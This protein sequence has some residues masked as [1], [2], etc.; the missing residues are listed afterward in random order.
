M[1]D[2]LE[3]FEAVFGAIAKITSGDESPALG[4]ARCPKCRASDFIEVPEL[5]SEAVGR[6]EESPES[7]DQIHVGGMSDAR[8]VRR[9][10]PPTRRSPYIVPLLFAVPLGAAAFYLQRRYGGTVG[11]LAIIG[12]VVVT[13]VVLMTTFRKRSDEYYAARQ[14]WRNLFMCRKCG[15]L[16]SP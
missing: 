8:I 16:V 13:I 15:Q 1:P 2:E 6:I 5:Y 12:A 3:K 14:Q 10:A 4:N 11:Q 9:L 7:A